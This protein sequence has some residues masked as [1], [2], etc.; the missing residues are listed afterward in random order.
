MFCSQSWGGNH[1]VRE[2]KDKHFYL[3]YTIVY[4]IIY[5]YL[6]DFKP[7]QFG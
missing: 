4:G 2:G 5:L 1:Y 6:Q 3:F 7:P